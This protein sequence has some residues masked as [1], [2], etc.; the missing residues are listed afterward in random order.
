MTELELQNISLT[1]HSKEG[2]TLA[3]DNINFAVEE[4]ELF[5]IVGPSGC[6]KT[7]ILSII[8]GL[9]K[10][11]QGKVVIKNVDEG[12]VAPTG[13]MLQKDQLFGWRSIIKN[14]MLGLEIKKEKTPEN[15]ALAEELL[16]KYGLYDFKDHYPS[17]LSGGMRQRVAL[18]RTLVL[19][20][21]I[22]LLDEP[23]SALDFQTRLNV[24]QDVHAII[25]SEKKTAVFVTHDLS[26]AISMCDKIAVLSARPAT[27]K[28]VIDL[29]EIAAMPPLQRRECSQF[30]VVFERLWRLME[31]K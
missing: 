1:Y 31:V 17:Q 27:V 15:I 4:G 14:I 10:P 22:L 7:T 8:S 20:P 28:E 5:G 24:C 2:E 21:E 9:I 13:Y 29:S 12:S 18:I 25:K 6:G 3:L 30:S 19:R 11:S 26:E 16:K 23:F